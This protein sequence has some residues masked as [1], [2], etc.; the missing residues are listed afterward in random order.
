M[1]KI[2][3]T[4]KKFLVVFT[5][6]VMFSCSSDVE[7]TS[8]NDPEKDSLEAENLRLKREMDELRE[9]VDS[10][11]EYF[12]D[13]KQTLDSIRVKQGLISTKLGS[14]ERIDKADLLEDLNTLGALMTKNQETINQLKKSVKN[15]NLQS[16]QMEKMIMS[17]TEEVALKN[18]E[19]YNLQQELETIDAAYTEVLDAYHDKVEELAQATEELNTSF[20]TFGTAKELKDNGVLTKEGGFIGIGKIKRLK[21]DFN[22]QY[23]TEIDITKTK[24]IPLGVAS[25]E[26]LTNHPEGSYELVGE[27]NIEKLVIKNAK[28]FWSVS[29]YL[30]IVVE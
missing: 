4:M 19:I 13:V 16:D 22:K 7:Q 25:A 29:K 14:K 12:N 27:K 20:F 5:T 10:Y 8:V 17:L 30:V 3:H 2:N 23:F 9:G 15:S 24:S 28:E 11:A 26:L 18:M 1:N 21:N 6:I